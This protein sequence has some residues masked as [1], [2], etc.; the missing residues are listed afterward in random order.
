M[1]AERALRHWVIARR[2]GYGTR[3]AQGSRS[4]AVLAG[5]IDTCGQRNLSP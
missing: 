2:N 5:V 1:P 4:V 3:N